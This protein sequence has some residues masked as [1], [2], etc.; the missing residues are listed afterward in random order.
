MEKDGYHSVDDM[1]KN[2]QESEGVSV[3]DTLHVKVRR[4][5][6][7]SFG[8]R[9]KLIFNQF[10]TPKL[11]AVFWVWFCIQFIVAPSI[12]IS[13]GSKEWVNFFMLSENNFLSIALFTSMIGHGGIAHI[14]INS[15]VFY[16]FGLKAEQ[17]FE[18]H[19][20]LAFFVISGLIAAVA[21]IGSVI[22]FPTGS[23]PPMIGASGAIAGV[24]GVVTVKNPR[25]KIYLLFFIPMEMW[26]GITLFVV[27]S[28]VAVAIWG[29]GAGGFANLAHV[30]GLLFGVMIGLIMN[31]TTN[32]KIK[33][34]HPDIDN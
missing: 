6:D 33:I 17:V 28:L 12:G 2:H 14:L 4:I 29:I 11:I 34:N 27:G 18:K 22:V 20:Y 10:L 30:G 21:Q 24:I 15:F 32:G 1:S 8:E 3:R 13:P 26:L 16:Q 31:R 5:Q 23:F 7:L 19:E 9:Q 25:E